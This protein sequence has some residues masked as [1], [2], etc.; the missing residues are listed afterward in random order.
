M[1]NLYMQIKSETG[2]KIRQLQNTKY[3][4]NLSSFY[5][6]WPAFMQLEIILLSHLQRSVHGNRAFLHLHF[7]VLHPV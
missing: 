5:F 2:R 6:Y 4:A 7:N 1:T 3:W